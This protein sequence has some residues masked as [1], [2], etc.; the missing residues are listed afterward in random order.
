MLEV[1]ELF[2]K[3][4][5]WLGDYPRIIGVDRVGESMKVNGKR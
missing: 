5:G 3:L 4:Q 2:E 1:I